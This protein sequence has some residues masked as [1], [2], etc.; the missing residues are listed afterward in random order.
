MMFGKESRGYDPAVYVW[1]HHTS[2]LVAVAEVF[3]L[4]P[5]LRRGSRMG[6]VG[7]S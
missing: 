4:E 7:T 5:R 2:E 3:R 6:L 1:L